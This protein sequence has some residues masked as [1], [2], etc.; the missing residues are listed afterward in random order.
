MQHFLQ[1]DDVTCG[2]TCL[3]KVYNFYGIDPALEEVIGEID[4]NEDGGLVGE[5]VYFCKLARE[6]GFDVFVDH[7]LSKDCG[8]VG[9]LEYKTDHAFAMQGESAE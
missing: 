1:P 3:R 9:M 5:D 8:H 2:P 7:D 4:R 6:R